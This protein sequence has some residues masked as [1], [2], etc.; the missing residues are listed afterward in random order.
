MPGTKVFYECWWLFLFIP[1]SFIFLQLKTFCT[2]YLFA[3]LFLWLWTPEDKN[4]ILF[5]IYIQY[6][7]YGNCFFF[8]GLLSLHHG[9]CQFLSASSQ[10][11]Q[12]HLDIQYCPFTVQNLLQP[13]CGLAKSPFIA[14]TLKSLPLLILYSC[15]LCLV[16]SLRV[17]NPSR[18]TW[19]VH[20]NKMWRLLGLR[21]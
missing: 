20:H 5:I 1:S 7:V 21:F 9:S 18:F 17:A 16:Y 6:L 10:L 4:P 19:L 3:C 14:H 12:T 13:P 15:L 11:H 2:N 8:G